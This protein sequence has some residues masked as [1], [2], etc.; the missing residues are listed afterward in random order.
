MLSMQN[1]WI[2][3]VKITGHIWNG[4]FSFENTPFCGLRK[5][6]GLCAKVDKYLSKRMF[7][8]TNWEDKLTNFGNWLSNSKNRLTNSGNWL[9]NSENR[10][11]NFRNELSKLDERKFFAIKF[12]CILRTRV[13][14]DRF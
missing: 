3:V 2:R 13:R 6:R 11:T 7:Y 9:S 1:K 4:V 14:G 12:C 10:L 5:A 8:L